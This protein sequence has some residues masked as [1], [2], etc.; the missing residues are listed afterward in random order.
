MLDECVQFPILGELTITEI[1]F[2]YDVP[3][4]FVCSNS[5]KQ[6][7]LLLC[8][9][10]KNNE[11][12]AT[13]ITDSV[14]GDVKTDKIPLRQ[15]F[16]KPEGKLYRLKHIDDQVDCTKITVDE[17]PFDMLPSENAYLNKQKNGG[18]V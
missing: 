3:L 18:L 17:L 12:I 9:S 15:P 11:Y 10:L 13:E 5:D 2:F 6:Q 8:V 7:Y 1:L 4:L 14:L 16:I